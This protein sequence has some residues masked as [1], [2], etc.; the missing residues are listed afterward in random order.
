[1][2]AALESVIKDGLSQ[3][4]AADLH[5]VPRS[6]LKDRL[7]GKV[8]HGTNPGPQSYLSSSEELELASFLVDAVKMGYSR[9]RHDVKCL[10]ETH[11]QINGNKGCANGC[12]VRRMSSRILNF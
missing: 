10:V 5:G 1:M 9:T 3:N 4:R 2:K 6:T 7:S 12:L 8:I 11:L